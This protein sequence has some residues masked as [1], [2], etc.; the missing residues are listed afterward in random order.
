MGTNEILTIW[1]QSKQGQI[2]CRPFSTKANGDKWYADHLVP[3]Q[4]G[5]NDKIQ[6]SNEH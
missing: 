1:Y 3:K 2:K 6:G 4:N 5:A